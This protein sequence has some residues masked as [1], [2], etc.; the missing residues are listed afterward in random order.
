MRLALESRGWACLGVLGREDDQR[1]AAIGVDVVLVAVPDGAIAQVARSVDPGPAVLV[2]LSGATTLA[3][4]DPH[5]HRA[6]VHPLV[7]LPDPATGADR[8][9]AGATFAV[10]GHPVAHRIVTAL[11]GTAIEVPDSRRAAYHAAASVG[12]NHLVALCAQVERLAAAAQVPIT[13]YW[14]LMARTLDNVR[15]IGA[16]MALT[17]PAA[18]GDLATLAAHLTAIDPAEHDLY[19]SLADAAAAL[20][21]R[22]PPSED[23]SGML[24]GTPSGG[25]G[26]TTEPS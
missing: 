15:E 18:R 26:S 4:L 22:T 19:L 25:G 16:A 6:S 13:A 8:L 17:G 24:P 3:G 5:A 14:D 11:G 20:A 1:G 9:M 23:L 21:G 7:S 2:H 12:A 10:A